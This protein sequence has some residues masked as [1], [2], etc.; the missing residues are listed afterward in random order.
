MTQILVS[1]KVGTLVSAKTSPMFMC[2]G[3]VQ[4]TSFEQLSSLW[5]LMVHHNEP[6]CSVKRKF[7]IVK[8]T[9]ESYNQN[10]TVSNVSSE[11]MSLSIIISLVKIFVYCVK[12]KDTNLSGCLSGQIF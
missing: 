6:E 1:F 8:V 3:F 9:P 12:I 5:P 10:M 4:T 7:F 11:V 2:L